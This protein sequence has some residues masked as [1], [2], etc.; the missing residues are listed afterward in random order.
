[1]YAKEKQNMETK[2]MET[3]TMETKTMKPKAPSRREQL[4][5]MTS[6][7]LGE[8]YIGFVVDDDDIF[9][10]LLDLNEKISGL[11]SDYLDEENR[12]WAE[13]ERSEELYYE[14]MYRKKA[15]KEAKKKL[16]EAEAA[17]ESGDDSDD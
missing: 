9:K 1:M 4:A 13:A 8:N 5:A 3:K 14:R 11:Y 10:A 2:T 17:L 16:D 6:M 15:V 7:K 12:R